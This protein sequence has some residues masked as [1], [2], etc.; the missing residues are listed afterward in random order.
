MTEAWILVQRV[1]QHGVE[2]AAIDFN[3]FDFQIEIQI[4]LSIRFVVL[5]LYALRVIK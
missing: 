4:L 2:Y 1:L 5:H 3:I